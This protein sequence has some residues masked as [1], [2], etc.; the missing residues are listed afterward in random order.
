MKISIKKT[1]KNFAF[2]A[3]NNEA[4]FALNAGSKLE[5]G[6]TGFRPMETVL[7]AVGTCMA[8]D[9]MQILLKQ[10]QQ[11]DD[12]EMSVEGDRKTGGTSSPF[13]AFNLQLD[14]VGKVEEDKLQRAI[15]LSK[16]KYCSVYHSMNADTTLT[17]NFTIKASS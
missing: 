17:V 6:N 2:I 14:I 7:V 1:E 10:R 4:S 12:F 3:S 11:V 13:T 5:E 16:D 15:D 9:I 8:I